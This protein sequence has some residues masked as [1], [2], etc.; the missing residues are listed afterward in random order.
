MK[1][2]VISIALCTYNGAKYIDEQLQ[3]IINQDH[4]IHEIVIVD[5][6]ST[7]NTIEIL[8]KWEEKFPHLFRIDINEENLAFDKNFEKAIS[9]CTGE[10]IDIADQDDIWMK[11]K[12]TLL[13][14]CFSNPN[15]IL[16]HGASVTLKN[17]RLHYFSGQLRSKQLFE[18]SDSRKLFLLNQLSGH[19]IIF[20]RT[21]LIKALPIPNFMPYDWWLALQASAQGEIKAVK[22]YLVHHRKHGENAFFSKKRKKNP[23]T[24]LTRMLL[25]KQIENLSA[26]S[27][28]FLDE[29]IIHLRRHEDLKRFD[30]SYFRF[31]FKHSKIIFGHKKRISQTFTYL[32]D[33]IKFSK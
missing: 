28:V 4:P 17:G 21:L 24:F 31:L 11:D 18:G 23:L 3:T 33:S 14:D 13:A 30:W 1:N 27:K 22:K 20:R 10:L 16:A 7:D 15:V 29:F 2:A 8:K 19:N 9:L 32:T 5:D 12:L 6:Q 25:F 26:D